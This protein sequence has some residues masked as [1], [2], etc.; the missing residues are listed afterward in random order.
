MVVI[1]YTQRPGLYGVWVFCVTFC[2]EYVLVM[3]RVQKAE[4]LFVQPI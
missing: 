2:R 3:H 4:H 1:N